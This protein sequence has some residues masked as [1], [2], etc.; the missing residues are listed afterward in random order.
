M[1]N[2]FHQQSSISACRVTC[3]IAIESMK[4]IWQRSL[5]HSA[6]PAHVKTK[7]QSKLYTLKQIISNHVAKQHISSNDQTDIKLKNKRKHSK[8]IQHNLINIIPYIV[9]N[10]IMSHNITSHF[11]KG[12]N[13]NKIGKQAKT[14]QKHPQQTHF[15]PTT[16]TS[17]PKIQSQYP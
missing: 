9:S 5:H 6:K 10:Y 15:I 12:Q 8:S 14:F 1:L 2:H 13:G 11:N 3:D 17:S 16:A 4:H 7:S